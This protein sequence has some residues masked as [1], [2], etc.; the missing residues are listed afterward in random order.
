MRLC[1]TEGAK[2]KD[3][4]C[5]RRS[6]AKYST[7]M[8]SD[9]FPESAPLQSNPSHSFD[10]ETMSYL[11]DAT[12]VLYNSRQNAEVNDRRRAIPTGER[13]IAARLLRRTDNATG[14]PASQ[15]IAPFAAA[16]TNHRRTKSQPRVL[17]N[18]YQFRRA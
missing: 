3:S 5:P 7:I 8:Q 14:S 9:G 12:H 4:I 6:S 2:S 1:N 10:R 15:K 18:S 16:R 17:L 11:S 13:S